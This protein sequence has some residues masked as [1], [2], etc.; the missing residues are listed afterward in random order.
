[1]KATG[2][3]KMTTLRDLLAERR[4]LLIVSLPSNSQDFARAAIE[5]GADAVKIHCN[6]THR[7]TKKTYAPWV[8]VKDTA[9]AL[10]SSLP[11]AVGIVPG[12]TAMASPAELD[13]MADVGLS[14][15]DAYIERLPTYATR[16]RL[17]AM[18][19]LGHSARLETARY[20]KGIGAQAVEASTVDASEYGAPLSALDLAN[21]REIVELSGL[22][23]FVPS[24]KRI[25]PADCAELLALGVR[26]IILGAVVTGEQIGGYRETIAAF[27]KAMGK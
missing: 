26:G 16:S 24:Q 8:E 11:G 6:V 25:T 18:Y 17:L 2:G 4:P 20:L 7:V 1:M 23:V 14:F 9:A 22:P 5:G 19:S 3:D 10:C 13:E 15:F 27:A 12:D 21:Y